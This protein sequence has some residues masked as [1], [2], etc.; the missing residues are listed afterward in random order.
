MTKQGKRSRGGE[1][2]GEAPTN[3]VLTAGPPWMAEMSQLAAAPLLSL[4]RA[5]QITAAQTVGLEFV[6]DNSLSSPRPCLT[7]GLEQMGVCMWSECVLVCVFT[8]TERYT[9]RLQISMGCR[10]LNL[11]E[12]GPAPSLEL[13]DSGYLFCEPQGYVRVH[14]GRLHRR[15]HLLP[16]RAKY[17][18]LRG[19][20]V[21][22][23]RDDVLGCGWSI[24]TLSIS[25]LSFCAPKQ[26][27]R[28]GKQQ[29]SISSVSNCFCLTGNLGWDMRKES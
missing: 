17:C 26:R 27:R 12:C 1:Q 18:F 10:H 16:Q 24:T 15:L 5:S 19:E 13:A 2:E 23:H 3:L 28:S 20:L 7:S 4:G 11:G 22:I 29:D 9:W 6:C 21:H 14:N 8:C 25:A